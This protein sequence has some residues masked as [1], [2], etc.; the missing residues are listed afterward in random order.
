MII[1][2]S[3][4]RLYPK[5]HPATQFCTGRYLNNHFDLV[6]RDMSTVL[7]P[8]GPVSCALLRG[9]SSDFCLHCIASDLATVPTLLT[10]WFVVENSPQ[11]TQ[12]YKRYCFSYVGW[13]MTFPCLIWVFNG[14]LIPPTLSVEELIIDFF[15]FRVWVGNI[16]QK[17]LG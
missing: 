4:C 14:L 5:L 11:L 1:F 15:L 8:S 10:T 13:I 2:Q 12:R 3:I 6:P 9:V 7:I 17:N 16:M